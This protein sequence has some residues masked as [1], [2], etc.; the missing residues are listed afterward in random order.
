VVIGNDFIGS[1]SCNSNY[2]T[3]QCDYDINIMTRYDNVT[4]NPL[5]QRGLRIG[6]IQRNGA[7]PGVIHT[8]QCFVLMPLK[9]LKKLMGVKDKYN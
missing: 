9:W 5:V 7:A 1:G 2:H 3:P 4:L 8:R 6:R